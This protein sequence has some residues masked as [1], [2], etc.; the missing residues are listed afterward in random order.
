M[1]TFIVRVEIPFSAGHR[2]LNYEGKCASPHGH[3]FKAEVFV[4][5]QGVND[6]GLVADFRDIKEP[7]KRWI[8]EHWDH[9][10]LINDRD[11]VMVAALKTVREAKVGL[12]ANSNPSSENMAREIFLVASQLISA[13]ILKARIWESTTQYAEYYPKEIP[14]L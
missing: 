8:D 9:A 6:L 5:G 11:S 12:F 2:L 14:P 4:I 13:P 1:E 7:L 3:S 10:F